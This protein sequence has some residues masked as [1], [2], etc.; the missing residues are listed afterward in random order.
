MQDVGLPQDEDDRK[1][2]S[3]E[4]MA[5][6]KPCFTALPPSRRFWAPL[7]PCACQL[8]PSMDIMVVGLEGGTLILHRTIMAQN[9]ATISMSEM[10]SNADGVGSTTQPPQH[11]QLFACFRPDGR[12]LAVCTST[13]MTI[14]TL[15]GV[16]ANK[17]VSQYDATDDG[18]E[19]PCIFSFAMPADDGHVIPTD[20][21]INGLHWA[22]CGNH[23]PSWEIPQDEENATLYWTYAKQFCNQSPALL[24]PSEYHNQ[25]HAP[26]HHHATSS[27]LSL[28]LAAANS[29]LPSSDTPLSIL[30]LTTQHNLHVFLHGCLPILSTTLSNAIPDGSIVDIVVSNDLTHIIIYPRNT[31]CLTIYSI[32]VISEQRYTLQRLS[33]ISCSMLAL[34]K[35]IQTKVQELIVSWKASLKPLDNKLELLTSLLS[36][37]GLQGTMTAYFVQYI[38]SGHTRSTPS[39]ANAMDQ[40]FTHVQMNDQLLVRMESSLSVAVQN[41]ETQFRKN[42]L[43]PAHALLFHANEMVGLAMVNSCDATKCSTL[44]NVDIAKAVQQYSGR[45]YMVI[46]MA[47]KELV[48]ARFRIRDFCAWIRSVGSEIKA[49]G[50][51]ANSVQRENARARR[52]SDT[53]VKRMLDY[54]Q[55]TEVVASS[56]TET[57]LGLRFASRLHNMSDG[58]VSEL[59]TF[60]SKALDALL[61]G[62]QHAME[63]AVCSTDLELSSSIGQ[64]IAAIT[65]RLGMGGVDR[66]DVLFGEEPHNGFFAPREKVPQEKSDEGICSETPA[67]D[68][69]EWCWIAEA[70]CEINGVFHDT[71]R[72]IA[73]PLTYSGFDSM[74]DERPGVASDA[75]WTTILRL[76]Y[77]Y[78]IVELCFY[79]DNGKSAL[80]SRQDCGVGKERRQSLG[81]LVERTADE[82]LVLEFWTVIY[83]HCMFERRSWNKGPG[84]RISLTLRS[85]DDEGVYTVLPMPA[86]FEEDRDRSPQWTIYAKTRILASDNYQGKDD[87]FVSRR[88][89]L[90][91]SRGI[92]AFVTSKSSVDLFDLED[93]DEAAKNEGSAVSIIE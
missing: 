9:I 90:S 92:G 22:H 17:N 55:S 27:L 52:V 79:G 93:N 87:N 28:E 61:K 64:P 13:R 72:L 29:I 63:K 53:V 77:G 23:H 37:Y 4:R 32:P 69:N 48:D 86:S 18:T 25:Q 1:V 43:N 83:D 66:A 74:Q 57:V 21:G 82:G 38:L 24:P 81:L 65:T 59:I 56:V 70:I 42:L 44:L 20:S 33:A 54:L 73:V 5:A 30:C 88:L 10:A 84:S 46:E 62:P 19:S 60:V 14:Y 2:I 78:R 3:L 16:L 58:S 26:D 6:V 35:T 89:H 39:L 8:C 36:K 50:T 67:K 91:G 34:V 15:E 40:F 68:F 45:L 80:S 11:S 49:N 75:Y 12:I 71:I 41:V 51:G 7:V 85:N 47:S 31:A 76:S